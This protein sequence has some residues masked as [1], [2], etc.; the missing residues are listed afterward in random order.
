MGGSLFM[1]AKEIKVKS[2]PPPAGPYSQAVAFGKLVFCSGQIGLDPK[3]G[4]LLNQNIEAETEQAFKN[5]AAVLASAKTGFEKVLKVEV[6][7]TDMN[8]FEKMNAVYANY[9]PG[10]I[11]PVR[12]T[13]EVSKLPKGARIEITCIAYI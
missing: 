2:A 4:T 10:R 9:F 5:M 13:V 7:L 1:K 12:T 8:D 6:F 11:K 3:T